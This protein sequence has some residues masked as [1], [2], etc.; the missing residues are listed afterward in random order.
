MNRN[1][2]KRERTEVFRGQNQANTAW[3]GEGADLESNQ[4]FRIGAQR[5][6]NG[7]WNSAATFPPLAKGE[8]WSERRN[9]VGPQM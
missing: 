8:T 3:R 1:A 5:N 7:R 6:L 9:G 2:F 4:T